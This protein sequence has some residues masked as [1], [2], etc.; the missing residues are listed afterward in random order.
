MTPGAGILSDP[1]RLDRAAQALVERAAWRPLIALVERFARDATPR[2]STWLHEAVGFYHL[3]LMDRCATRLQQAAGAA[4]HS[5]ALALWTARM[6][7]A[8]GWRNRAV[9]GLDTWLRDHPDDDEARSLLAKAADPAARAP[10]ADP[11]EGADIEV[12]LDAARQC[13]HAGAFL[14]GRKLIERAL[15]ASD[16]TDDAGVARLRN[17]ALDLV[18]ALDTDLA[19]P[20]TA[21]QALLDAEAWIALDGQRGPL[22]PHGEVAA[23][24]A[25]EA[26]AS[27]AAFPDLFDADEHADDP[28]SEATSDTEPT[29]PNGGVPAP[30]P[31]PFMEE[32]RVQS[33]LVTRADLAQEAPATPL[34]A[35]AEVDWED[36]AV[37]ELRRDAA[38]AP[39]PT[40]VPPTDIGLDEAPV[41]RRGAPA[42]VAPP[43]A[44]EDLTP[45]HVDAA[46]PP[47]DGGLNARWTWLALLAGLILLGLSFWVSP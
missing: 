21:G 8:R 29:V 7:L 5:R 28:P 34:V 31:S 46:E 19:R 30:L 3:G 39:P 37:V 38:D 9:E 22:W 13:L 4:E 16:G 18:W 35:V 20:G 23:A 11:P 6:L 42:T 47:I 44:R 43:P 17:V 36:D 26:A 10:Q 41:A 14:R 2:P 45:P 1:D 27:T 32:T 15:T 25:L 33:V 24:P 12:L 40:V